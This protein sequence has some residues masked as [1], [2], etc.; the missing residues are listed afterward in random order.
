MDMFHGVLFTEYGVFPIMF[1][2]ALTTEPCR[3]SITQR[4]GDLLECV[5]GHEGDGELIQGLA[6]AFIQGVVVGSKIVII[7]FQIVSNQIIRI[8]CDDLWLID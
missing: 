2:H 7:D 6:L 5:T 3:R 4:A 1:P 8:T